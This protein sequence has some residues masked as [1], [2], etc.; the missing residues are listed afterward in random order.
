MKYICIYIYI[1]TNII[2]CKYETFNWGNKKKWGRDKYK[3]YFM[4]FK[5]V[6]INKLI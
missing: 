4:L 2:T 1:Y 3:Q 6:I 5:Q